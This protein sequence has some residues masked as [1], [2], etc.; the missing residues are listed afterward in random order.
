MATEYK[1]TNAMRVRYMEELKYLET[2]KMQEIAQ[3]INEARSFGDLSENS[4]YDEAKN[5]QG[6]LMGRIAELRNILDNAVIISD[7]ASEEM[8]GIVGLGCTV[9]VRDLEF[10]ENEV[11]AIVGTQEANPMEARIS[12]ESPLG[13]ALL[14]KRVGE[15]AEYEAPVGT[16]RF[17]I[18][19]V[20]R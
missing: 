16:V 18:L 20:E 17:E 4:E 6:E 12:D 5:A 14:G 13:K 2:E 3:L 10:D 1:I 19:S 9:V 11:F 7:E 8:K 15:I